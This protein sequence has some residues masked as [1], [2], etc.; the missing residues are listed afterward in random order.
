MRDAQ[1][2]LDQAIVQADAGQAVTAAVV[3]DMLGL[4]DRAQTIDLFEKT[5]RGEAGP[6]IEAFRALYGF[7]ADPVTVMLDLLEHC[8]GASVAKALGP[9]ALTLPKDQA[10]RLGR[11]RRGPV[12]RQSV[13]AVA[14]AAQGPRRGAPRARP[15]GGRGDGADPSGLRRRP[16]GTGGG[17]EGA[18]RRRRPASAGRGR[19]R[20]AA[21]AAAGRS[22]ARAPATAAG[23]PVAS[24][25]ANPADV[26][27]RRRA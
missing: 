7:G 4:A 8:H 25:L 22:G 10:A 2:L 11:A 27:G 18:S 17:A 16:A 5:V 3:R 21:V 9:D 20:A 6:A 12:G 26:R 14:D 24:A 1:S 23:R 19:L 13:A 15:G